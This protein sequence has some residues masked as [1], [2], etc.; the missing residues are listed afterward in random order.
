MN[1]SLFQRYSPISRLIL[2]VCLLWNVPTQASTSSSL[3]ASAQGDISIHQISDDG[4]YL[5]YASIENNRA[6]LWSVL[7]QG[8]QA[9]VKLSTSIVSGFHYISN[10]VI[11]PDSR[12][13]A[14]IAAHNDPPLPGQTSQVFKS[15]YLFSVP[16][17]GSSSP[18]QLAGGTEG[19]SPLF[20]FKFH[21]SDDSQYLLYAFSTDLTGNPF[22]KPIFRTHINDPR[23]TVKI[24]QPIESLLESDEHIF[25]FGFVPQSNNVYATYTLTSRSS[26]FNVSSMGK[27]RFYLIQISQT[28]VPNLAFS[29]IHFCGKPFLCGEF[30][31]N[32][33][34]LLL[35]SP[36]D[37]GFRQLFAYDVATGYRTQLN[38]LDQSIAFFDP[39]LQIYGD[40]V[41]YYPE[42]PRPGL[43]NP[44]L[45]PVPCFVTH[46]NHPEWDRKISDNCGDPKIV[47]AQQRIDY[48][49]FE[50]TEDIPSKRQYYLMSQPLKGG[51]PKTRLAEGQYITT[52]DA[53]WTRRYIAATDET[54]WIHLGHVEDTL[55]WDAY[56]G[57][58]GHHAE[59]SYN[60]TRLMVPDSQ[61]ILKPVPDALQRSYD[62]LVLPHFELRQGQR[63]THT[64][65]P[66]NCRVLSYLR[67]DVG[68]TIDYFISECDRPWTELWW[69]PKFAGQGL[70]L[71][72]IG[73]RIFAVWFTYDTAGQPTWM[74]LSGQL[75]NNELTGELIRHT[76]PALGSTWDSTQVKGKSVGQATLTLNQARSRFDFSYQI[77][78]VQ[79]NLNL[80]PF[81]QGPAN[82][83]DGFW[84][85]PET[86][87]QGVQIYHKG[88]YLFGCAYL[89]DASGQSVWV[90]FQGQLIGQVFKAR[91]QR[92]TGPHLGK[93]WDINQ[94][95]GE[96][97]G[98]I[99]LKLTGGK[100]DLRAV[101][102]PEVNVSNPGFIVMDYTLNGK[103]MHL[104][105]ERF[106]F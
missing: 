39:L 66:D 22:Q 41:V 83:Y 1:I 49:T 72:Q 5:V 58:P 18:V 13:V 27:Q 45:I 99:T 61:T 103:N 28:L 100:R 25:R 78:G 90:T 3:L 48:Q 97:V 70:R 73:D 17:D 33:Q 38:T 92:F 2:L 76:G 94:V 7:T 96:V 16:L 8:Q 20:H 40:W 30:T 44:V 51:Q 102:M 75:H 84:W 88:D 11:S 95:Q 98:D 55:T 46:L 62:P 54:L 37:S 6:T 32:G 43:F 12:T 67:N 60:A 69:N 4:R 50:V 29:A 9:P 59:F 47:L 57:H 23:Q 15:E 80:Q 21:F 63:L 34:Q 106:R 52:P 10:F 71:Q 86:S 77:E 35:I 14:Y 64:S 36:D 24:T 53:Q 68:K 81:Y 105:L 104:D 82:Q 42:N 93:A 101:N 56:Q 87:G 74:T 91:L 89:Y 26:I 85:H 31:D 19:N 79:G 65:L